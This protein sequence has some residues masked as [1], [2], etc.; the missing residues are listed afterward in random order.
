MLLSVRGPWF[1]I[2]AWWLLASG[3]LALAEPD[4]AAA[5]RPFLTTE[6]YRAAIQRVIRDYEAV[7]EDVAGRHQGFSRW[8]TETFSEHRV[9]QEYLVGLMNIDLSGCPDD[10]VA[11][12][13][14]HI[15]A[16]RNMMKSEKAKGGLSAVNRGLY[17]FFVSGR[18]TKSDQQHAQTAETHVASYR[19][20]HE[21]A[22]RHR[23]AKTVREWEAEQAAIAAAAAREAAAREA[24]ER[25]AAEAAAREAAEAAAE[26]ERQA[27][28]AAAREAA[29]AAARE[30]AEAAAE[31]ERQAA[32]NAA[33]AEAHAAA[34]AATEAPT[35]DIAP[36]ESTTSEP[37][38]VD[39]APPAENPPDLNSSVDVAP[40]PDLVHDP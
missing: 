6:E 40:T 36:T 26:A 3:Q 19:A 35:A 12:F 2:I 27:A 15:E 33:T 31:A 17:K 37:E 34:S 1:R 5:A 8:R 30:A 25:E 7:M 11:A 21:L 4:P 9:W 13:N 23:D 18:P 10:F 29:E 20:L 16:T 38:P 39:S 14:A 24:A 28:E 32:E 22:H